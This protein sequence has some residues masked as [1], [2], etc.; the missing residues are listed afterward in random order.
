MKMKTEI[1]KTLDKQVLKDW[2]ALW[3]KSPNANYS[4]SP[5]WL[6]SAI[7]T[8][9]YKDY[10][11]IAVYEDEK[12]ISAGALI[13]EKRYGLD[14]YTIAP[15]DFVC[16]VPFLIELSNAEVVLEFRKKLVTLGNI[17]LSNIPE[18]F[19]EAFGENY[20]PMQSSLQTVNYFFRIVKDNTGKALIAKRGKLIHGIRE[21][22]EK[23]TLRSFS[24]ETMDGLDIA[25]KL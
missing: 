18:E 6:L 12:L 8:F 21:I 14:F 4:N 1:Y 15:G 23:V 20:S 3:E 24:G 7:D 10:A 2:Q 16:G 19:I 22:Q 17:L 11:I 13:K 9:G 5:Q 25:F